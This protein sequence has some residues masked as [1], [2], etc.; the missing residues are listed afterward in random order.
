MQ[1]T[2]ISTCLMTECFVSVAIFDFLHWWLKRAELRLEHMQDTVG[3]A[4]LETC[5]K[6]QT[7]LKDVFTF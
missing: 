2:S 6:K 1:A 5:L 4:L 7:V 3:A